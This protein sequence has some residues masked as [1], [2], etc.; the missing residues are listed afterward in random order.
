MEKKRKKSFTSL[1][2]AKNA[3]IKWAVRTM[4]PTK[5]RAPRKALLSMRNIGVNSKI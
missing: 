4:T 5:V 1:K 2:H 3:P